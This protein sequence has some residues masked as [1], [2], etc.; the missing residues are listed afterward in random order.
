MGSSVGMELNTGGGEESGKVSDL[1]N[2]ANAGKVRA[3]T[4]INMY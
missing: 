3:T 1:N 4:G 2:I